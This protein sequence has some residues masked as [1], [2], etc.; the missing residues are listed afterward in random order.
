MTLTGIR[1]GILDDVVNTLKEAYEHVKD[2][3]TSWCQ[4]DHRTIELESKL[5]K[6]GLYRDYIGNYYR[7]Y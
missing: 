7:G 4:G 5:L 3:L 2:F 6:K 1:N